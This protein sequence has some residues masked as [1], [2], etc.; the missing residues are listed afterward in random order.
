MRIAQVSPLYESCPPQFYGGTERVV[1]YLTEELIRQGHEVTLFASGDSQ[2]S[3]ILRAPCER[4][5]A[6]RP[7]VPGS[8][9]VS[10]H[11]AQSRSAQRRCIRHHP[12]S[13]GLPSF[14]AVRAR[15]AEDTDNDA[16]PPRSAGPSACVPRILDDAP[17]VNLERAEGACAVGKLVWHGTPRAADK[18]LRARLWPRWLSS[19]YWPNLPG[20]AAR[21]GGRDRP[22]RRSA[23]EDRGKGRQSRSRLLQERDRATIRGPAGHV[24]RRNR[25]ERAR[26]HFSAMRWHCCFQSI[27]PSRL[28]SSSSKQW[29]TGH[30]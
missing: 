4:A 21:L 12:F 20:E 22:P 17:G 1:S 24:H 13:H 18:P 14:L 2:T 3:A 8:A 6:A 5:L 25:R 9:P 29:L 23:A 30:R 27:G 28:V 15:L 11:I 16:R 10:F 19:L 26:R 7:A